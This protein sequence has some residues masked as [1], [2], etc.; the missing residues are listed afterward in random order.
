MDQPTNDM[1]D[2]AAQVAE[3]DR[4]NAVL[5][6]APGGDVNADRAL[7]QHVAKLENWFFIARGSAENPSPYSLA[8]EPGMMICIYSSAARAQEAARLSGLVEPGA[9]GVPLYA[10]PV[11]MAINYVAAFAQTGAFGVTIDY[12]QIR[13]YTALANL[14]MLKKW[15]EES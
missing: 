2:Q 12:P 8:A 14:G 3:L 1:D 7:W 6:S 15:L 11:P 9:E 4:L 5:N 13:A 10:M